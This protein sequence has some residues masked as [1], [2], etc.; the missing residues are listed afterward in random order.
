MNN[1]I[2]NC[3]SSY[4]GGVY[5]YNSSNVVLESN[6]FFENSLVNSNAHDGLALYIHDC[7]NVQNK[8]NL[9]DHNGENS[10]SRNVVYISD[11]DDIDFTNCTIID[12][13]S[14]IGLKLVNVSDCVLKNS[15]LYNNG[16]YNLVVSSG[17]EPTQDYC[18]IGEDPQLDS[19]YKPLWNESTRS[20]VID[21]GDSDIVDP[22]GTPSDIG[23]VRAINHKVDIVNLPS[24]SENEGWKWLCFPTLD[25]VVNNSE[26]DPDMAEYLLA[27]IITPPEPYSLD[28]VVGKDIRIYLQQET[29]MNIDHIFTSI[30]GYKFHMNE[31]ADI[32]VTGFLE[33][34]STTISLQGNGEENWIGYF[35]EETQKV[36]DAFAEYWNGD[37]IYF[38]QHQ[39]WSAVRLDGKW[40]FKKNS[41]NLSP[42][43]SYGDMVIVKCNTNMDFSWDNTTPPED[44]RGYTE[45]EYFS[46]TEQEDYIPLFIELDTSDIPLEIGAMVNGEC[47]GATV[48]E[49][50]L[51]QINAYTTE[52]QTGSIE[53]EM[54]YGLRSENKL[55]S[56]YDCFSLS[57]PEFILNY[58]DTDIPKDAYFIPL[59]QGS[60]LIL[61]HFK[62][63]I[64]NYPNPF[65]PETTI[66]YSVPEKCQVKLLIYNIKG[67]KVCSL[68]NGVLDKG[69]YTILWDGKDDNRTSI[70]SGIYFSRF[71]AGD[72]TTVK[73]MIM[74]K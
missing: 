74:L 22:D 25:Y 69:K 63:S 49:D 61:K 46:Y 35:L 10:P 58:L 47:I 50:T 21:A 17:P 20:C 13:Y 67:Q 19:D 51:T 6:N 14:H 56:Q 15:V 23:A 5:C 27:D 39:E 11:S 37:N 29:W 24:P 36:E 38:I 60:S 41:D 72:K 64:S 3:Q 2:T 7:Q 26:F 16:N 40:I 57:N 1:T 70:S 68:V 32:S 65:N 62:F 71:S 12:N 8:L 52:S 9:F 4:G 48:V 66:N 43:L 31:E 28:E 45:P 42:T 55:L 59:K 54:Y 53:F 30:K 44:K 18:L 34:T 73:K 33:D